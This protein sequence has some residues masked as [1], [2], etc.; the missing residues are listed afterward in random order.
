V[1]IVHALVPYLVG[2]AT[3]LIVQI[4]IQYQVVPRVD[5]RRRREDRWERNVLEL[6]ELLTNQVGGR[7][8]EARLAQSLFRAI[9]QR[10]YGPEFDQDKVARGIAER[11]Q[12]AL[13]ATRAFAELVRM[14]ADWLSDRVIAPMTAANRGVEF[15]QAA[16]WYRLR[17]LA[18]GGWNPDDDRPDTEFDETWQH[19]QDTRS[20]LINQVELLADL[21]HPPRPS[22]RRQFRAL[23][24]RVGKRIR[25]SIAS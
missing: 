8:H 1:R 24:T 12:T 6:G 19:E 21:R 11:R 13:D 10:E 20:A 15:Q 14:R 5:T 25:R 4:V 2:A 3:T 18:I 17:A 22:R 9:S 23:R 16:Y 7:A